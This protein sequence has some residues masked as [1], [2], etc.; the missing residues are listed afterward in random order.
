MRSFISVASVEWNISFICCYEK[1]SKLR[2]ILTWTWTWTWTFLAEYF[3][4]ISWN[5]FFNAQII[6]FFSQFTPV[7]S[8]YLLHIISWIE[9]YLLWNFPNEKKQTIWTI[10]FSTPRTVDFM[11]LF[12]LSKYDFLAHCIALHSETNTSL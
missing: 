1:N 12:F 6:N 2:C 5:F 9:K 11:I 8:F 7:C 4:I 10:E 3:E